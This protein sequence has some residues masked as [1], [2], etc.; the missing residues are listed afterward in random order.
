MRTT[1]SLSLIA[2]L[3]C[4]SLTQAA[5]AAPCV[6]KV[7]KHE[8]RTTTG[9]KRAVFLKAG[10]PYDPLHRS[11]Y[12]V[13]HVIPLELAGLDAVS[14][15]QLQTK[16][17]G[18]KKDLVENFLAGCVCRGETPLALAQKAVLEWKIVAL[19]TCPKERR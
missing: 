17:D 1:R 11:M 14:N 6:F 10:V 13:D 5:W 18:H 15:M 7:Q 9:Q 16:V 3:A 19:G 12:V 8:R 4:L 2:L